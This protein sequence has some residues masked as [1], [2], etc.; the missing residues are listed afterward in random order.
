[1]LRWDTDGAFGLALAAPARSTAAL[2]R[3][4]SRAA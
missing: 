1:V 3:A 4:A 2:P